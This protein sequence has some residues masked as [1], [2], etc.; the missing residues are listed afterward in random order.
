M[1]SETEMNVPRRRMRF[2]PALQAF[3]SGRIL[4]GLLY[5]LLLPLSLISEPP[6]EKRLRSDV[7]IMF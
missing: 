6:E 5:L 2:A 3:T 7:Y 1:I 4:T